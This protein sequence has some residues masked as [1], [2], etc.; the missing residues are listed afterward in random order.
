M[1]TLSSLPLLCSTGHSHLPQHIVD[2]I[3]HYYA[4]KIINQK[5][6][7]YYIAYTI[8]DKEAAEELCEKE[9]DV[10]LFQLT[11]FLNTSSL[12]LSETLPHN[13]IPD[14]YNV[15]MRIHNAAVH[16]ETKKFGD[17]ARLLL[18]HIKVTDSHTIKDIS[19]KLGDNPIHYCF[20]LLAMY[21]RSF[22]EHGTIKT[23]NYIVGFIDYIVAKFDVLSV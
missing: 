11:G 1:T 9:T 4:N 19:E 7:R 22:F 16:S 2:K 17:C 5:T 3:E 12:Y 10:H 14:V 15:L 21:I 13:I 6:G 18:Y 20:A 23:L 8:L